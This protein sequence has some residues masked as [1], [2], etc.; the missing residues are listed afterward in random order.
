VGETMKPVILFDGVCNLCDRSVQFILKRDP[1]GYFKFASLQ[2][3]SGQK[4][5]TKHGF[6]TDINSFVLVE[7]EKVFVKSSAALR[8][9]LRLKGAWKMLSILRFIPPS[10]RDFFYDIVAKNRYKWFG[11]KESCML[12][13]PQWKNRFLD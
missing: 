1:N 11:K 3:E 13:S 7:D 2:S 6:N 12:P 8:V 9:C 4:L 5:L 10:I